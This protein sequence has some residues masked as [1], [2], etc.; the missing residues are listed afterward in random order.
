MENHAST[1]LNKV[2]LEIRFAQEKLNQRLD[3]IAD[4]RQD[5]YIS[6][7]YYVIIVGTMLFFAYIILY[8][9]WNVLKRYEDKK[10]IEVPKAKSDHEQEMDDYSY[11]EDRSDIQN[12]KR[13]ITTNLKT[14]D[15]RID[16]RLRPLKSFRKR[17]DLD[18]K[19]YVKSTVMSLSEKDDDYEFT[20]P[21]GDS[22]WSMLFQKPTYHTVLNSDPHNYVY[23]HN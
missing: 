20:K 19:R 21:S 23:A 5:A 22:V 12:Y 8:D 2:Q 13:T 9:M 6:I 3:E 16:K 17:H 10:K 1:P 11:D 18:D 14:A 4:I 15:E 7:L